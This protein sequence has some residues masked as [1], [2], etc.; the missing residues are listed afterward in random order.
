VKKLHINNYFASTKMGCFKLTYYHQ[1]EALEVNSFFS[2]NALEKKGIAEKKRIDA[3]RYGFQGQERDDEIKGS[4]NSLN[5]KYRMHDPRLGRFLSLDPLFKDY[6]HNSPYAFSENRV[7]DAIELEGA[8]SKIIHYY[9]GIGEQDS[10]I[11]VENW[12]DVHP[13]EDQ[14]PDGDG[15]SVIKYSPFGGVKSSTY[16]PS[17]IERIKKYERWIW[18]LVDNNSHSHD[19]KTEGDPDGRYSDEQDLPPGDDVDNPSRQEKGESGYRDSPTY[20]DSLEE[21][22]IEGDRWEVRDKKTGE[23]QI[24]LSDPNKKLDG[25]E[26]LY[27]HKEATR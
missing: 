6:P 12:S 25:K 23:K 7:I 13:G 15:T 3:Y 27:E 1:E 4:G 5:Y 26:S 8:E 14:G 11:K 2:G 20:P 24:F 16:I 18:Q 22:Q 10:K 17:I 21:R 9:H 19:P